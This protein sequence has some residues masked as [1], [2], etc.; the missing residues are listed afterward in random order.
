MQMHRVLSPYEQCSLTEEAQRMIYQYS[1]NDWLS[2]QELEELINQVIIQAQV[3]K[4]PADAALVEQVLKNMGG[5]VGENG[6]EMSDL[7]F[8]CCRVSRELN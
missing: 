2:P 5:S 6:P 7:I 4:S 8:P 3:R 1:T